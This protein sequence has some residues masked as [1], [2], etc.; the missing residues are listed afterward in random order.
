MGYFRKKNQL[1]RWGGGVGWV[2]NSK[3]FEEL[4]TGISKRWLKT[5][6]NLQGE[7]GGGSEKIMRKFQG[8]L[9]QALKFPRGNTILWSFYV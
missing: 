1:W 2:A 8:S 7:G 5:K 3:D 4:P 9:F 6:W